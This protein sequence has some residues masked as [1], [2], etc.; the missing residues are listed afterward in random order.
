MEYISERIKR[1]LNKQTTI[2][3]LIAAREFVGFLERDGQPDEQFYRNTQKALAKLY[4]AGL[5]FEQIEL[6]Y[7]VS[8][9]DDYSSKKTELSKNNLDQISNL[10]KR[11]F[12]WEVFDPAYDKENEPTQ[13]WLVDDFCDIYNDLKLELYKIEKV[14]T[15]ESIEDALWQLHFGFNVHWGI[16][17][18]NASRALFFVLNN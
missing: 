12:Y 17:C 7:S 16:H 9:I 3:L 1:F 8:P 18:I 14:K 13:G 6:E 4:L 5:S 10:G 15:N 11:C 2:D